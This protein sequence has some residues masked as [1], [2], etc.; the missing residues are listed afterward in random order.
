M[1]N[2]IYILSDAIRTGKT[3]T[4]KN[5]AECTPN[6]VGFLSPEIHGRRMFQ[7]IETDELIPM[8]TE[9]NDLIVGK[10]AFDS[11]SFVHVKTEILK[12]WE[13]A[14]ADF[15]VLDEIGPLEIN[16]GLGFHDLV[17]HLQEE[18][19][20]KKPNLLFVVRDNCLEAFIEKYSFHNLLTMDLK[21]FR[22]NFC[23]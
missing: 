22:N 4:L 10:F 7:D 5:W 6:V 3:T 15:I 17:L 16:K 12:A 13:D 19:S 9:S 11:S 21:Q 2:H 8:E 1:T 23:I 14:V 20:L 18:S